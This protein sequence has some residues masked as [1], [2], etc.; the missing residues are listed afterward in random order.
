MVK[1]KVE[2]YLVAGSEGVV[3]NTEGENVKVTLVATTGVTVKDPTERE[4]PTCSTGSPVAT[5][6][7]KVDS[8]GEEVWMWF[9]ALLTQAGYETW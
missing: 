4:L 8:Q 1:R 6:S 2:A 5:D 9:C 3:T 7:A